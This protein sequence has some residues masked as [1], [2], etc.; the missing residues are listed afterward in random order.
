MFNS[1]S[2]GQNALL[3]YEHPSL[4]IL[5]YPKSKVYFVPRLIIRKLGQYALLR[6]EHPLSPI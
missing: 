1:N 3:K 4:V 6:Y 5:F 2:L